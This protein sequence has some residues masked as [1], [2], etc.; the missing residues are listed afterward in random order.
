[1]RIAAL[2]QQPARAAQMAGGLALL[3]ALVEELGIEELV[4]VPTGLRAGVIRELHRRTL[5]ERP[6]PECA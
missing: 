4:P 1:M 3:L 5:A 2:S 6:F